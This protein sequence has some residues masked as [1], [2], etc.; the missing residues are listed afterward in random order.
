MILELAVPKV[1]GFVVDEE[2]DEFAVGDIDGRLPGL[3][4]GVSS[5]RIGQRAQLVEGV[6]VGAGKAVWLPLIEVASQSDVSVGEGKNGLGLCQGVEVE[7][8]LSDAPLLDREGR[9]FDHR[10]PPSSV[11]SV[12]LCCGASAWPRRSTPMQKSAV[13]FGK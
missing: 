2:T 7:S 12:L 8:Y 11:M 6:Q 3:R 13:L 5:L 10:R 1:K 4:V 9:M